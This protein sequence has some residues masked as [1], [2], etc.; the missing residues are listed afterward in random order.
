M[1]AA[2]YF[3]K[4]I[5]VLVITLLIASYL[6]ILIANM[7]GFIDDMIKSMLLE[8]ITIEVKRNPQ[9]RNLPP[10]EQKKII[11]AIYEVRIKQKGLDKPFIERSLIYLVDALSLNLGRAMFLTS[12][13]GSRNVRD[14]IIERLPVTVMLFTTA[15][16]L[17]FILGLLLGI[18]IS[19]RPGSLLDK[20]V[21]FAA[22]VFSVIPAWFY[23][24]FMILIFA[25][26]LR[27]FP[28]GGLVSVPPPED[29][30]MYFLDMLWHMALPLMTWVM[31]G[32]TPTAYGTRNL[33]LQT[34]TEDFVMVAKAKGLPERLIRNRY[35]IR[36]SLPPIITNF[37][38]AVI[39]SWTGAIIS[40]RVFNWPGLGTLIYQA[41]EALDAPVIIGVSV[42]YAYLL[43]LTV[44]FLDIIYSYVDP[45]IRAMI[46]GG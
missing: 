34:A 11:D 27:L 24:I 2:S 10:V 43:V 39:G 23:G 45:R 20:F 16:V 13:T 38:L 14:I 5:T 15:T 31:V 30:V 44:L 37:S 42:V 28:Y 12:D 40:E 21:I 41:I 9:Y 36:P 22:V 25:S 29:P 26:T 17:N 33:V 4:K 3:A 1:G 6:T 8:D 35:I 7:G 46:R 32:I 18:Y 19:M